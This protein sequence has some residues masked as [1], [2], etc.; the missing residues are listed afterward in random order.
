MQERCAFSPL[1]TVH[2]IQLSWCTIKFEVLLKS[3]ERVQG[4][5]KRARKQSTASEG[6]R[7]GSIHSMSALQLVCDEMQG[8]TPEMLLKAI[9]YAA[10][11]LEQHSI[12]NR[13]DIGH[14]TEV[15]CFN[16]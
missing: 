3:P 13:G 2:V 14:Q 6:A 8:M 16:F 9:S 5:V 11:C 1:H 12:T 4:T 15:S 7:G 10:D